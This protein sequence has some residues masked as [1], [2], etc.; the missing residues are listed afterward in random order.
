[1]RRGIWGTESEFLPDMKKCPFCAEEIQDEAILCRF[2]NREFGPAQLSSAGENPTPTN[3]KATQTKQENGPKIAILVLLL[4]GIIIVLQSTLSNKNTVQTTAPIS[5][6]PTVSPPIITK[7]KYN[8]VTD[9]MTYNEVENIIG[10][11]GED[12]ASSGFGGD[13]TVIYSWRNS[14]FSGA[15]ITFLNGRVFAKAQTNLR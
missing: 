10:A 14:D 9:G 3:P 8:L 2:C 5:F 6:E 7:A 12:W 13:T 4:I 1:V 11:R 15:T